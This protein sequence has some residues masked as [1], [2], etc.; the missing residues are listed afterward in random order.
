MTR[1]TISI[2]LTTCS[3]SPPMYAWWFLM[4]AGDFMKCFMKSSSIR[5]HSA[6]VT[7]CGFD[8]ESQQLAQPHGQPIDLGRRQRHEIGR[9]DFLEAGLADIGCNQLQ[10]ALV[11]LRRSLDPH[12]IAVVEVAVVRL[13]A[14]HMRALIEPVRSD[15]STCK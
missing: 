14:F 9:V 2:R 13:Q 6:R 7:S 1:V 4:P 12:E 11:E 5:K 8:I 15:S 3:S 10:S